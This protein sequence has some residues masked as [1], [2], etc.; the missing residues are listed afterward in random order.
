MPPLV[1]EKALFAFVVG[2][3]RQARERG[4]AEMKV[5]FADVKKEHLNARCDEEERVELPDELEEQGRYAKLRR[6]RYRIKKA[7]P[8]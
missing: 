7:A 6:W 5:M 8:A 3:A 4:L 1:A 2:S